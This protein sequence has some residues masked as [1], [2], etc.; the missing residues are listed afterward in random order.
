QALAEAETPKSDVYLAVGADTMRPPKG[1][2]LPPPNYP[3]FQVAQ[4]YGLM[5]HGFETITAIAPP[6]MTLLNTDPGTPNPY[7]GIPHNDALRLLLGSL[8]DAQWAALTDKRG[9]GA[10]DM[11]DARQ[12]GLFAVLFPVGGLTLHPDHQ[13]DDGGHAEDRPI[14]LAPQDM[15]LI[16]LHLGQRVMIGLPIIVQKAWMDSPAQTPDGK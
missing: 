9:L 6:S 7:D 11:A 10:S 3:I 8:S 13:W 1:A 5:T 14:K 2:E 12:R 16:R 4:A 15:A